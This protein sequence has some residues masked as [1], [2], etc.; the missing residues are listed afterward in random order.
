[1]RSDHILK[2]SEDEDCAIS[3]QPVLT[4]GCPNGKKNIDI[5]L[6]VGIPFVF[7]LMPVAFFHPTTHC[8]KEP[9]SGLSISLLQVQRG[10]CQV[11][12]TPSLLQFLQPLITGRV[13][14]P[15]GYL[16]VP[17]F[18]LLQF[19][20]SFLVPGRPKLYREV[21][22]WSSCK[23]RPF[24]NSVTWTLREVFVHFISGQWD[25]TSFS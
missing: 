1:M 18:N 9:L 4:L 6:Y 13:F 25:Q 15:S 7:Q 20:E 5:P 21:S 22:G 23:K 11:H 17:P 2:I 12:P 16:G 14:L 3:G 24:C 8:C 10:G 19:I